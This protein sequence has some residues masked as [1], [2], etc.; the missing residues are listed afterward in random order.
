MRTDADRIKLQ[1]ALDQLCAWADKW[2]MEFDIDKCKVL[3][4][5]R[6]NPQHSYSM[7]GQILSNTDSEKYNGVCITNSL[8]PSTQCREAYRV[9]SAMLNNISKTFHFR[10]CHVFV[11][12]V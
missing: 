12:T 7:K 10:D 9:A 4:I 1:K 6:N 3:H 8:K 2:D 5:G 11:K